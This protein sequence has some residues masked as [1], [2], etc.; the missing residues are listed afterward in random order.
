VKCQLIET[1][2]GMTP[3]LELAAIQENRKIMIEHTN[4]S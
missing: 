3:M 1:G 2:L 4:V